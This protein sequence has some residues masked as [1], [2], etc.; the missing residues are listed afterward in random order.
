MASRGRLERQRAR[1]RELSDADPSR[2][3]RSIAAEIGCSHVT[4]G[5]VRGQV[6][7][8]LTT[9]DGPA[10]VVSGQNPGA[11]NLIAPAE[12]G[13]DRATKHGAYSSARRQPLEDQHREALRRVYP[14]ASDALLNASAK[15]L[16]MIELFSAWLEDSG[17]VIPS[18]GEPKVQDAARELRLLLRDHEQ[19]IT[20]LEA[21][22]VTPA[23][24]AYAE[25]L[26]E[27]ATKRRGTT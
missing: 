21:G 17:V 9:G 13:N 20:V 18:K 5:R 11:A 15:R 24:D 16:S 12:A 27:I 23:A 8:P 1:I 14:T 4:V 10:N 7:G 6:S 19:A 26:R 25:A 2:S 3:H 22:T